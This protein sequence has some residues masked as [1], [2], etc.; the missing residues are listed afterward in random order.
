MV[1][2]DLNYVVLIGLLL[3]FVLC[4]GWF[5]VLLMVVGDV[6]GVFGF[7][8]GIVC[9]LFDVCG[10]GLGWVVDGVIV[11]IVLMFGLFVLWVCVN[12]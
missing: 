3:L 4:D 1:G 9:V 5:G 10:G 7:V 11:D 6:G 8:F 2:Y 12:G